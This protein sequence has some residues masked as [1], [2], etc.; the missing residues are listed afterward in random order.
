MFPADKITGFIIYICNSPSKYFFSRIKMPYKEPYWEFIIN[1]I[2]CVCRNE[3][4]STELRSESVSEITEIRCLKI[5]Q[6]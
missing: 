5:L 4:I 3:K 6:L 2:K 1:I